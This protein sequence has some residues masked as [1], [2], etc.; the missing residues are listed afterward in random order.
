MLS[1]EQ[2]DLITRTAPGTAAGSSDAA[3]LAAGGVGR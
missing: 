1:A 3:L 2:N